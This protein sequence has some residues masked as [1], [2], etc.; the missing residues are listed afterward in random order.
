MLTLGMSQPLAA[1]YTGKDVATLAKEKVTLGHKIQSFY[2][3]SIRNRGWDSVSRFLDR[4]AKVW[5]CSVG[6]KQGL[7]HI[8]FRL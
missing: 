8:R 1:G 7:N 6:R 4:K 3:M 2:A 5:T